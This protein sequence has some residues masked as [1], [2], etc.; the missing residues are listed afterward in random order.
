VARADR[1]RLSRDRIVE[2]ALELVDRDGLEGLSMRRLGERLGVEAMSLYN[3]VA[4]KDA[5]LDA[6]IEDTLDEATRDLPDGGG[7]QDM[8]RGYASALRRALLRHPRAAELGLRRPAT[9]P[10][11]LDAVERLLGT[12]AR[13]GVPPERGLDMV[14][15]LSVFVL[16]HVVAEAQVDP[17]PPG[18]LDP[19]THPRLAEAVAR[20]VARPDDD[21]E[22]F[23]FAVGALIDGFA[24]QRG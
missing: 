15:A 21:A 13:A 4:G 10:G 8:L 18:G 23:A 6:L 2:A 12:L 11:S 16:A 5:L 14:N 22:R 3:H 20:A 19:Q 7:W 24:L 9:T 1:P 17:A